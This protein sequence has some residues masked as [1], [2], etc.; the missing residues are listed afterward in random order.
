MNVIS[1]KIVER[2][3]YA[4]VPDLLVVAY[5]YDALYLAQQL[6]VTAAEVWDFAERMSAAGDERP[7][8]APEFM[9]FWDALQSDRLGSAL[10]GQDGTFSLQFDDD[11]FR[12]RDPGES[13]P[14]LM[15]FVLAPEDTSIRSRPLSNHPLERLLHFSYAIRAGAGRIESYIIRLRADT[16]RSAGVPFDSEATSAP[17]REPNAAYLVDA[18][19][20]HLARANGLR[21]SPE[22]VEAL[23]PAR[24]AARAEEHTARNFA[25]DLLRVGLPLNSAAPMLA[26]SPA[27]RTS[28]V[29]SALDRRLE[30]VARLGGAFAVPLT[31]EQAR[32]ID[33]DSAQ[34]GSLLDAP[35]PIDLVRTRGLLD[36]CRTRHIC[37][38][39]LD[40]DDGDAGADPPPDSQD[41]VVEDDAEETSPAV[42]IADA[43]AVVLNRV[44]GQIGSLPAGPAVVAGEDD[45]LFGLERRLDALRLR[46]GAADDVAYYDLHSLQIAFQSV[47][48]QVYGDALEDDIAALYREWVRVREYTGAGAPEA[49]TLSEIRSLKVFLRRVESD[50]SAAAGLSE[51]TGTFPD[52]TGSPIPWGVPMPPGTQQLFDLG[53]KREVAQRERRGTVTTA[54]VRVRD[55]DG[56]DSATPARGASVSVAGVERS[57][58]LRATVGDARSGTVR[59]RAAEDPN[60]LAR[61]SRLMGGL[62]ARLSEPYAFDVFAPQTC[63]FGLLVTHRQQWRPEAYQAGRLVATMPLAPGEKRTFSVKRVTKTSRMQK[64]LENSLSSRRGESSTTGRAE[65]EIMSRAA[66]NNTFKQ[67]ARVEGTIGVVSLGSTTEFG[68]DQRQESEQKKRDFRESVRKAAEEYKTERTLELSVGREESEEITSTGEVSN[69][70]N[71]ITVTY[72]FYELQRRYRVSEAL[73]RVRPVVMV[74]QDVPAPEEIDEAWLVAHE[75]ILRRVLLDDNLHRALDYLTEALAGD[76]MGVEVLRATWERNIRVV[77]ALSAHLDDRSDGRDRVRQHLVRLLSRHESDDTGRDVAAAIFSGGLSLLFGGGDSE[78]SLES[79]KE[80]ASRELEFADEEFTQAESRLRGAISA[81]EAST[82]KYVAALRAQL[83]RRV[84]V[85]QLRVHVKENILFY[86]QAIWSHEPDDQRF[87]RLYQVQVPWI[88]LEPEARAA[89]VT[90]PATPADVPLS[91][92]E[93]VL[94]NLVG[95]APRFNFFLEFPPRMTRPVETR[96]LVEIADVDRLIGFKGNYM[97]FPLKEHNPLTRYMMQDYRVDPLLGVLDPDESGNVNSDDLRAL[98]SCAEQDDTL[99]NDDKR[100]LRDAVCERLARAQIDAETVVVPT[101]ELFVEALPGAR[102]VLEEFKLLHRAIDV[103]R[104]EADLRAVELENLRR[105]ARIVAGERDDPEIDKNI[106]IHGGAG[107]N[108][109]TD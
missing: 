102:P 80:A 17:R 57:A 23:R 96:P 5:D 101:G 75:W 87:F 68:F 84:S 52:H 70:N 24:E 60:L 65:A 93:G 90:R 54:S 16:L 81:L 48:E 15:L 56:R 64:E 8:R 41:G 74:A 97:I 59:T 99:S 32:R 61:V 22:V 79:V 27:E 30:S 83:N 55:G 34:I 71:E 103:R 46:G 11:L 7:L 25:R 63:N 73:H 18:V 76:E 20:T 3:S 66:M 91:L 37:R 62:S 58:S 108:V 28:L 86:M 13:R 21:F 14:D 94:R 42:T 38:E 85:D 45:P 19:T 43:E 40:A 100:A 1:G 109:G 2:L 69:P 77:E 98:L 67:N 35:A 51:R 47:W 92:P 9:R 39:L 89:A 12:R 4:A 88:S 10:T 6:N 95:G 106:V 44:V 33:D 72:L 26:H 53:G 49:E 31:D 105:A 78:T 50:L 36:V 104:A 29:A 107:V 82:D